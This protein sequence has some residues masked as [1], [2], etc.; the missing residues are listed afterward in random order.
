MFSAI[1]NI[2]KNIIVKNKNYIHNIITIMYINNNLEGF[3]NNKKQEKNVINVA[4]PIYGEPTSYV[5]Q[6]GDLDGLTYSIWL[7]ILKDLEKRNGEI[8]DVNYIVVDNPESD[9]LVDGLKSRKYDI[10]LGN[11]SNDPTRLQFIDYSTPFM[12]VKDVGVYTLLGDTDA[13]DQRIF[14]K[15]ISV[16]YY[17]FIGLIVLSLFSAIYAYYANSLKRK[18]FSGAFVQ[19]MNGILGDRG[20]LLNGPSFVI[21]SG[22]GVI[23]WVL[24]LIV[25]IVSFVF[26]FYLQSV[27]ISKSLDIISKNKDPFSYPEGKKVLV[28]QG[29]PHSEVLKSCCGI[30]P[31]ETKSTSQD[32]KTLA[33]EYLERYKKENIAGFYHSGMEVSV[34]IK[35]N[36]MFIMSDS[37]FSSPSPVSYMV[38]KYK[39][40]FLYEINKSIS[41]IQWDNILND[42]CKKFIGR[43][44]FASQY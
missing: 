1:T 21:K 25:V 6:A 27:A 19:M 3:E 20:G 7:H 4:V 37:K 5:N 22:T 30:I 34:W 9:K 23:T 24:A 8:Y 44:C 12:S 35:E 39:P 43:L 26:L 13:L 15:V 29:S 28:S 41:N 17:P 40:E 11:F 18:N 31:V 32:V 33:R 16:L 10:V 14:R 2:L 36:P 38:T 42:T